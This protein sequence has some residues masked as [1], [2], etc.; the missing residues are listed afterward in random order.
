[1]MKMKAVISTLQEELDQLE[2]H[3]ESSESCI[4]REEKELAR[5]KEILAELKEKYEEIQSHILS[6]S[7]SQEQTITISVGNIRTGSFKSSINASESVSPL[8][9]CCCKE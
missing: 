6:L 9:A 4:V 8:S 2:M 5:R 7:D 3:I 1:M